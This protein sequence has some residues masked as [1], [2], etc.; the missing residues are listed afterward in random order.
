MLAQIEAAIADAD[1]LDNVMVSLDF[2]D[3]AS[4]SRHGIVLLTPPTLTSENYALLTPQWEVHIIAG[5]AN[6]YLA[7]WS[8]IDWILQALFDANLNIERAE[9]SNFPSKDAGTLPAYSITLNE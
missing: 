3:V 8:R 9:P 6:N 7:A 5:P 1:D 2:G 4:G